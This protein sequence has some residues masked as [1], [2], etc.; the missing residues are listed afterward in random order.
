MAL[1]LQA[2]FIVLMCSQTC[3]YDR[4]SAESL[5]PRTVF[6]ALQALEAADASA[7]QGSACDA[8][9]TLPY[10]ADA[11]A[12]VHKNCEEGALACGPWRLR[13]HSFV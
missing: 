11:C 3:L 8:V 1:W 4:V 13:S 2:L 9:A 7:E 5:L 10:S 12:Y 6:R